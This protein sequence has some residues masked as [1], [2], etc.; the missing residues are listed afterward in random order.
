MK[1]LFRFL[2]LVLIAVCVYMLI[3]SAFA[4]VPYKVLGVS[5]F[6]NVQHGDTCFSYNLFF[7]N[8]ITLNRGDVVILDNKDKNLVKRIIAIPGD[9]LVITAGVVIV[10]GELV[11]DLSLLFSHTAGKVDINLKPKEYFVLGDN[12]PASY[13]SRRMGPIKRDQILGRV[14]FKWHSPTNI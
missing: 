1:F 12:R 3:F 4:F 2:N 5:M 14:F 8:Q 11:R 13:D 6:P 10:N 7:F 9:H